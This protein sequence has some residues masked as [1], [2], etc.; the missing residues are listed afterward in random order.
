MKD[1]N[2]PKPKNSNLLFVL[3]LIILGISVYQLG[4]TIVEKTTKIEKVENIERE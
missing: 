4:N 1:S 2:E 3:I